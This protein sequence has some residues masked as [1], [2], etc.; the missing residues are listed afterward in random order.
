[1]HSVLGQ[2]TGSKFQDMAGSV[3]ATTHLEYGVQEMLP[4][5]RF[6][7]QML[8]WS[9]LKAAHGTQGHSITGGVA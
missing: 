3:G 5:N 1:M 7:K 9:T 2:L 4:G 6:E 8:D